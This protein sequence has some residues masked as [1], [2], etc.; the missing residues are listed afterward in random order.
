M[1]AGNSTCNEI[2]RLAAQLYCSCT[3]AL[4]TARPVANTAMLHSAASMLKVA[5]APF[6]GLA[7]LVEQ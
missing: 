5:E 4:S 2:R 3:S 1:Q 6:P 7:I